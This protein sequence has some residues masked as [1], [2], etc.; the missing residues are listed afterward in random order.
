[1]SQPSPDPAL[2]EQF[3]N[4]HAEDARV[5]D[6][7]V[8]DA[9]VEDAKVEEVN[10]A[11][12][13]RRRSSLALVLI[14][15]LTILSQ[16]VVQAAL[17]GGRDDGRLI[18]IAGRQ[19]MLSQQI[20]RTALQIADE[21]DAQVRAAQVSELTQAVE[22]W[23]KS[24]EGL[25]RGP[26]QLFHH[27]N[28]PEALVLYA[29]IE[30]YF[31]GIIASASRLE[32]AASS[33]S[34]SRGGLRQT[35]LVIIS[36]ASS[37]LDGMNEITYLYDRESRNRVNAI[38]LLELAFLGLTLATLAAVAL[39]IFR[40]AER[41]MDLNFRRIRSTMGLLEERAFRDGMTGLFNR[42]AG[43]LILE[44]EI[45]RA[46]RNRTAL[47]VC[48]IDID[49]LKAV[50]DSLGHEVGD[51]LI[52]SFASIVR[53]SIRAEDAAF[54][55][56][57]DEFVAVLNCEAAGAA[58]IVGRIREAAAKENERG[59]RPYRLEFSVGTLA[60]D[61][62]SRLGADAVLAQ[63]DKIMY[64]EKRRHKAAAGEESGASGAPLA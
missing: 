56:G 21:R 64:E 54:R 18:N 4:A 13:F 22:L 42:R 49:G 26:D 44:R 17:A 3:E 30:P 28:S 11:V 25:I 6:I 5:E 59:Q 55:Y 60:Y 47:I 8:E 16:F 58:E 43:L 38:R 10:P 14:A 15:V 52:L 48:F 57:G 62:D 39:F 33:F 20:A 19:R 63:A 45:Q 27:G 23:E 41:K 24:H 9:R 35:A 61:F 29:K 2:D 1:M 31:R 7:R 12:I 50:N 51:R 34:S 37:F 53:D 40:P 32:K 36:D 46:V